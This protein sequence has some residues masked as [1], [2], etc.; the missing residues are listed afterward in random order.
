M[1][2]KISEQK[3]KN[4]SR[5]TAYRQ[6]KIKFLNIFISLSKNFHPKVES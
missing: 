1:R 3:I 4:K 2:K 6:M 5:A